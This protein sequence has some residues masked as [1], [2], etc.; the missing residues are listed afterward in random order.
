MTLR[1]QT[2]IASRKLS[3]FTK[4]TMSLVDTLN[5]DCGSY[6]YIPL[7]QVSKAGEP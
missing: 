3:S 1:A 7:P 5:N 2:K 4:N 6:S